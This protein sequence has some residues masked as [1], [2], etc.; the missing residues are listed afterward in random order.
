MSGGVKGGKARNEQMFSA[1]P[2]IA[3]VARTSGIGSRWGIR[4]FV[5]IDPT[6]VLWRIGQNIPAV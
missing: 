5:I 2:P 4:D 3:T 1:L 6:R